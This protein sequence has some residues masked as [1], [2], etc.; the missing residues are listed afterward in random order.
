[1]TPTNQ[2]DE[3]KSFHLDPKDFPNTRK[4]YNESGGGCLIVLSIFGGLGIAMGNCPDEWIWLGILIIVLW[5]G[6]LA[7]INGKYE[8]F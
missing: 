3:Q 6:T 4:A 8:L 5:A 1:M 2:Q 7:L